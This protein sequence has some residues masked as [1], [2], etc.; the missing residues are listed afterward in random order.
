MVLQDLKACLNPRMTIGS[1]ITEPLDE[2]SKLSRKKRRQRVAE[3]LGAV[4][5]RADFANRY[6]FDNFTEVYH[7][8]TICYVPRHRQI[9]TDKEDVRFRSRCN[10][11]SRLQSE[12]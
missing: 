6:Q 8:N 9:V 1:I 11:S 7:G 5:M 2:D 10:S 12:F 3:L 4:G